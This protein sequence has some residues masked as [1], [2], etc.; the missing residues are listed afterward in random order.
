MHV[1]LTI[2]EEAGDKNVLNY[3]FTSELLQVRDSN[4]RLCVLHPTQWGCKWWEGYCKPASHSAHPIRSLFDRQ[5]D[6]SQ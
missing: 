6:Q 4:I 5:T 2:L 3:K 1:A